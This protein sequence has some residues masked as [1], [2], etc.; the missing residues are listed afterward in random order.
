[1]QPIKVKSFTFDERK[2]DP[3]SRKSSKSR[4]DYDSAS[5]LVSPGRANVSSLKKRP[6]S[7]S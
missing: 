1:M 2:N 3:K 7:I 4:G 5:N 6:K